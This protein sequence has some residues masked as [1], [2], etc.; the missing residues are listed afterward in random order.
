MSKMA[1]K[2]ISDVF[3]ALAHPLRLE[4]VA[5]LLDEGELCVCHIK[6]RVHSE[7]SNL[8][9]HLAILRQAGIVKCRRLGSNIHYAVRDQGVKG[10]I[11]A[12]KGLMSRRLA[13]MQAEITNL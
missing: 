6:D 7:Q 9:Q 3:K 10:L 11:D 13:E 4:V 8:S 1:N 5:L 12:A 2:M